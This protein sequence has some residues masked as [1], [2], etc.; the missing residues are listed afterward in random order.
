MAVLF[1]STPTVCVG[2]DTRLRALCGLRVGG[3]RRKQ[4]VEKK[5]HKGPISFLWVAGGGYILS[6][7]LKN[8]R[9]GSVEGSSGERGSFTGVGRSTRPSSQ[10]FASFDAKTWFHQA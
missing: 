8:G 3:P 6:Q 4:E 5:N 2:V 9:K 1:E 7:A 10:S